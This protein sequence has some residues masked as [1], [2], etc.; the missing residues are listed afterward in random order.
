MEKKHTAGKAE[1]SAT[2]L[3][4]SAMLVVSPNKRG[5]QSIGGAGGGLGPK[6]VCRFLLTSSL[7]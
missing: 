2:P 4:V 1:T 6:E 7:C 3:D 5:N